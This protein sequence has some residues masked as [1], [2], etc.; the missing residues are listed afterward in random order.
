M[1]QPGAALQASI[2]QSSRV[3]IVTANDFRSL[4][5]VA[6]RRA[7]GGQ[8]DD[9]RE[10]CHP[11]NHGR[12]SQIR[13]EKFQ[14]GIS[15]VLLNSVRFQI[16]AKDTPAGLLK[17]GLQKMTTNKTTAANNGYGD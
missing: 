2:C 4:I 5:H 10:S 15:Q 1:H 17:D 7:N 8:I 14:S 12:I 6:T 9:H 13:T 11:L 3:V 16:H